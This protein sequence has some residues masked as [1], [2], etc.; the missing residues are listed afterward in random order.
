MTVIFLSLYQ[1][2]P[3]VNPQKRQH[4]N[5]VALIEAVLT[6]NQSP[7]YLHSPPVYTDIQLLM[8]HK[9]QIML[10]LLTRD[11]NLVIMNNYDITTLLL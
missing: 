5:A 9:E 10:I 11:S 3:L 8:K 6:V 4:D 1:Q 2:K 7:R